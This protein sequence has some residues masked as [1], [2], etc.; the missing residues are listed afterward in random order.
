M[1][2]IGCKARDVRTEVTNKHIKKQIKSVVLQKDPHSKVR[3]SSYTGSPDSVD[4]AKLVGSFEYVPEKRE[5]VL[6]RYETLRQQAK[7]TGLR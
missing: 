5:A 7:L 1:V 4:V 6:K 3:M 2:R